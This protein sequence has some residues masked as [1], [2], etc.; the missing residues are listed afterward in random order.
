MKIQA[1]PGYVLV[2]KL[3]EIDKDLIETTEGVALYIPKEE[4]NII[5]AKVVSVGT[6]N[7]GSY[8]PASVGDIIHYKPCSPKTL[9]FKGEE[10]LVLRF[11]EIVARETK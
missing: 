6:A 4:C 10:L 3:E 8:Q 7:D 5:T 1:A 2:K 11:N 9:M